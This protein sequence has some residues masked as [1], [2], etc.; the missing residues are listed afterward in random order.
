VKT[1]LKDLAEL[2]RG[3]FEGDAALELSGV[4]PIEHAAAGNVTFLANKKYARHIAGTGASAIILDA[5][6]ACDRPGLAVIRVQD[7]YLSF[8]RALQF[9]HPPAARLAT[10]LD[11]T[12]CVHPEAVLG[13]GVYVGAHAVI[14]RGARVGDRT[15]I[16]AG[17][18]LTEGVSLGAECIVYPNAS[19]LARAQLGNRVIVHA[20][21]T[22]GSDGFGFAP[23]G[24]TWEKI[25]QVG[26]V[27]IGDDCEIGANSAIDRGALGDTVLG[28]GVK[29]DNLVQIAHNVQ[30]A[31]DTV[32][33]AQSGISGSTVIGRHVIIAGQVGVVGHIELGDGVTIGAQSGVSKSV[34]GPGKVFRGSPAHE[35]HDELKVEAALRRLPELLRS[36]RTLEAQVNALREELDAGA[37]RDT[38]S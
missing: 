16:H 28:R 3:T 15:A 29:I 11:A 26:S 22:I 5:A 12:S 8:A 19:L 24:D 31:D 17:A 1:T 9:F 36:V 10:A 2:L 13:E 7:P 25:P 20:G 35:I 23:V 27:R 18:V 21:A 14:E 32:I 38:P 30:I 4:A 33:A 37:R 34:E 6:T